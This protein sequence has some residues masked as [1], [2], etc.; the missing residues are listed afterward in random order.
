MT[1]KPAPPF[2]VET[3]RTHLH[4]ARRYQAPASTAEFFADALLAG[5]AKALRIGAKAPTK[6]E[7]ADA[8]QA[9]EV[10]A[11]ELAEVQLCACGH[12]WDDHV[13]RIGCLDCDDCTARRPR[14]TEGASS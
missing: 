12:L 2:Q 7:L 6:V 11:L 14:A 5:L 4:R 10:A 9:A 1:I 8:V 13:G 3:T